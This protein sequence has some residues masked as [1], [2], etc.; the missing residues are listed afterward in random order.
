MTHW[1]KNPEHDRG[2]GLPTERRREPS[3]D[4]Q[5]H[6]IQIEIAA[7]H[8]RDGGSERERYMAGALLRIECTRGQ[9]EDFQQLVPGQ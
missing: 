4:R 1:S 5:C 8:R 7:R 2:G 3:G 6:E 9:S